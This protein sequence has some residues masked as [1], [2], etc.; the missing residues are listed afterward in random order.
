MDDYCYAKMATSCQRE[1]ERESADKDERVEVSN[2]VIL[3]AILSLGKSVD[4]KFFEFFKQFDRI[5][6]AILS[7]KKAVEFT[8][9]EMKECKSQT[10]KV[11]EQKKQLC[12][13]NHDLEKS[14]RCA[15]CEEKTGPHVYI[16]LLRTADVQQ[17]IDHL[18]ELHPQSHGESSTLKKEASQ[19]HHPK[20]E[21]EE[22]RI[23]PKGE[24]LLGTQEADPTKLP[25][26]VVSVKTEDDEEKPQPG[27]LLAPLSDSEAGDEVE[28]TLSSDT[29]CEG[30]MKTRADNKH[31]EYSEK[32][33]GKKGLSCSVCGK[34]FARKSHLAE[35][36]GTH[37]G[38]KTFSCQVCGKRFSLKT[39][40]KRHMTMHAGENP[41]HCSVCSK[42]FFS[43]L[44]LTRHIMKHTGEKP[45]SCSVCGKRF[46]QRGHLTEHTRIH[47]GEK[48]YKCSICGR[49]FSRRS[50]LTGHMRTHTGEKPFV[51]SVCGKGFSIKSCLMGHAKTHTRE[52]TI[53]C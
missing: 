9:E 1:S 44:G 4:E 6:A 8:S 11:E 27:N 30:D 37:T 33:R 22:L 38:E 32:K 17:K 49:N 51:C 23:T 3:E 16:N 26:T 18:D 13:E 19:P 39:Y 21:E 46:S 12:K 53:N 20:G 43:R 34:K 45:F 40:L 7:L 24:C 14:K 31:S 2:G 35:H 10:K 36:A 47:T 48:P 5:T 15:V 25:L 42:P 52:K 50:G 29:D 41:F 28:V